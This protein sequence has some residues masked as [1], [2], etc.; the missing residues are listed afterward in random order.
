MLFIQ[1]NL[2][3]EVAE[4]LL[5]TPRDRGIFVLEEEVVRHHPY[6]KTELEAAF[7]ES[8][9]YVF[10]GGEQAKDPSHLAELWSLL[11]EAGAT[12]SS[13]LLVIGGGALLDLAGFAAATYMRGIRTV[14]IPTTLLAMVDASVGGKT[15]IDYLGVKNLIGAFHP[16]LTTC[17]DVRFLETLPLEEL[18]SGYGEMIKHA[19][20]QGP[21]TWQELLRW[22][23]PQTF[24]EEEWRER[25][26]RSVAYKA[27]IVEADPQ[28]AGLRRILNLGH[29]VGHALEAYFRSSEGLRTLTHGEA[30][31]FGL[32]IEGYVTSL[33]HPETDR[34]YLR[35][36]MALARELY[37]PCYYTCAA[38][39]ELLRLMHLDKKNQAGQ[40][41]LMG[42]LRPGEVIPLTG[43][44]E[45]VLKQGLDFLRETFGN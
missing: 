10:P 7:P 8:A 43:V 2:G 34:S 3:H 25:I 45:E 18:L 15:A 14:Y 11:L 44:S 33:L 24:S 27:S 1:S 35:T 12:R 22:G 13:L 38:Y 17:I 6:L 26:A 23:D 20:L 37:D 21:E 30:V 40:I 5:A 4:H 19:L 16:P 32:L 42:L 39:P 41:T 36:L 9:C 29:T 28:E 31:V